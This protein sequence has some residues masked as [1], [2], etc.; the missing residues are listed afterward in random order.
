MSFSEEE[1]LG[2]LR[3]IPSDGFLAES[4]EVQAKWL[5]FVASVDADPK[6]LHDVMFY[7][8]VARTLA[9]V[10]GSAQ[11]ADYAEPHVR[12]LIGDGI[13]V[14]AAPFEKKSE[15]V[16]WRSVKVQPAHATLALRVQA[17]AVA[18]HAPP[19]A[20]AIPGDD[21]LAQVMQQYVQTQQTELDEGRKKGTLSY[22]L[23]ARVKEVGLSGLPDLPSEDAMIRLESASMAAHA[24][25]R[26]YVGSAEARSPSEFRPSWTRTPPVD[27]LVGDGALEEKIRGAFDAR[28]QRSQ[29]DRVDYLSYANFQG[30]VLDWGVKMVVTKILDPV[31]LIGYKLILSRVAEE[32]GGAR[33]AYYYNLLLRQKLAKELENGAASVYGFL[34]HLDRD[35]LGDAKAKVESSAKCGLAVIW[36]RWLWF[37]IW[38][39]S[40][41]EWQGST[42]AWC[43]KVLERC[44]VIKSVEQT[45]C[46]VTLAATVRQRRQ[47]KERCWGSKNSKSG[48][49]WSSKRW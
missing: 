35:I 36:R 3:K 17:K 41:E 25:G 14:G 21:A 6:N 18:Q 4:A 48:D 28:K 13:K 49:T 33:T 23:K 45:W 2:A 22:D 42:K 19:S 9:E 43:W 11:P 1:V 15:D 12:S 37:A 44:V 16:T 46:Q 20:S 38:S 24:Q 29:Q 26:Q 27:V 10:M 8:I 7:A 5:H 31:H 40:S 39:T 32:F 34:M 30:H 47:T